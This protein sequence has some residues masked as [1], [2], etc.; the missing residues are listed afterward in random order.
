MAPNLTDDSPVEPNV[1]ASAP[2]SLSKLALRTLR[3]VIFTARALSAVFWVRGFGGAFDSRATSHSLTQLI[4]L[5]ATPT[6]YPRQ[7]F[8]TAA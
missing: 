1:A 2:D 4:S 7:R 5:Q 8:T 3:T 6:S